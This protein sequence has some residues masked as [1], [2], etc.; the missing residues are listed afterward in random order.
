MV[1]TPS[2]SLSVSQAPLPR[3]VPVVPLNVDDMS[4]PPAVF[5][6][7]LIRRFAHQ[8]PGII[9]R[10]SLEM[11]NIL[12]ARL[13]FDFGLHKQANKGYRVLLVSETNV[14]GV[15]QLSHRTSY[16]TTL[17]QF[18]KNSHFENPV[19]MYPS[20]GL[21]QP[22]FAHGHLPCRDGQNH[23]QFQY[24]PEANIGSM[25]SPAFPCSPLCMN[26]TTGVMAKYSILQ[27]ARDKGIVDPYPGVIEPTV[28]AGLANT[29]TA[30]HVEDRL[31]GSFNTTF[32]GPA[33]LAAKHLAK[34]NVRVGVDPVLKDW[35]LAGIMDTQ[36]IEEY[37]APAFASLLHCPALFQHK[38]QVLDPILLARVLGISLWHAEQKLYDTVVTF[39]GTSHQV[40]NRVS[41]IAE[42]VNWADQSWLPLLNDRPQCTCPTGD[43]LPDFGFG[44]LSGLPFPPL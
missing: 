42:A 28:I 40:L 19:A 41:N 5:F 8:T 39:P 35:C 34:P 20:A 25:E 4:L 21:G 22:F 9:V 44:R 14:R 31:T 24:G 7:D 11:A 13:S 16:T 43:R 15:L 12:R 32:A 18:F 2:L 6:A 37:S 26:Q 33:E 23:Y 17:P 3:A 29:G 38:L 30:W 27:F 36:R 1:S 10:P